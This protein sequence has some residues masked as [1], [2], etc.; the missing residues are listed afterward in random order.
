MD[1]FSGE[2]MG[3]PEKKNK[4][5]MGMQSDTNKNMWIY[6]FSMGVMD[7]LHIRMYNFSIRMMDG[8][9][10]SIHQLSAYEWFNR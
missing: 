4:I 9:F 8:L 2:S 6:N 5:F 10:M 3:S 7:G 1:L